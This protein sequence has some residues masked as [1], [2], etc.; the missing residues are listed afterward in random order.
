VQQ[1]LP[2]AGLDPLDR[3]AP[4]RY[5]DA[6][7]GRDLATVANGML[8]DTIIGHGIGFNISDHSKL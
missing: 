6:A 3:N 1:P 2:I 8:I 4:T 7:K 5:Y